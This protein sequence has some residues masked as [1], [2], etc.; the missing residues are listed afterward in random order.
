M[1]SSLD[2]VNAALSHFFGTTLDQN[3]RATL[4]SLA[5]GSAAGAL[6]VFAG[7]YKAWDG[8]AVSCIAGHSVTPRFG[9]FAN[10][11][12][13]AWNG[14]KPK[15]AS[16]D[17]GASAHKRPL[18]WLR[19][20]ADAKVDT[21][22]EIERVIQNIDYYTA[23]V[24]GGT[25]RDAKA[26]AAAI[27]KARAAN[28]IPDHL[29]KIQGVL[30]SF[31]TLTEDPTELREVLHHFFTYKDDGSYYARWAS[32]PHDKP[33]NLSPEAKAL[34]I[35]EL[36]LRA[37][38]VYLYAVVPESFLS[39]SAASNRFREVV[40]GFSFEDD[41]KVSR[42]SVLHTVACE[43]NGG[44]FYDFI[45]FHADDGLRTLFTDA[46]RKRVPDSAA[47][48]ITPGLVDL[49]ATAPDDA[50][51]RTAFMK[52]SAHIEGEGTHVPVF[53][54]LSAP[55]PVPEGVELF[56][57]PGELLQLAS[58]PVGKLA[59]LAALPHVA[60]VSEPTSLETRNTNAAAQINLSKEPWL[61]RSV[62]M[63]NSPLVKTVQAALKAKGYYAGDVDGQFG[64]DT[65]S[66][67]IKFQKDQSL[68]PDGVVG[69][70]T[71]G[72]LGLTWE[73]VDKSGGKGV[74]VGIIDSGIH[75][76]H[77]AFHVGGTA[78]GATRILSTWEPNGTGTPPGPR[79]AALSGGYFAVTYGETEGDKKLK[80][81][82]WLNRG[83]ELVGAATS[84][85]RDGSVGHGTHVA[86][87]AA[88]AAV[89]TRAQ[90]A[91]PRRPTSS[92][93]RATGI[94]PRTPRSRPASTTGRWFG[95]S[96][97]SARSPRT[98]P[99]SRTRTAAIS[100]RRW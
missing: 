44:D 20:Q 51:Q 54:E 29:D 21:Q 6:E 75:G 83:A 69:P 30:A 31:K 97:T 89:R 98:S 68:D 80:S 48:C 47:K 99:R 61:F 36:P 23:T 4:G 16:L 14:G 77:P 43:I 76:I 9:I 19:E 50:A 28:E 63:M 37:G 38:E 87:I 24:A 67:V 35:T 94:P 81:T 65:K 22:A 59:E 78:G 3:Q 5:Q 73:P 2:R 84:A 45:A 72:K 85:M 90:P 86:G 74:V 41:A 58:V 12:A 100:R 18:V 39:G 91:W 55:G 27:V 1:T 88:G 32:S 96:S 46:G 64:D 42:V 92:R 82:Q 7:T 79:L 13:L 34:D 8:G 70:T 26:W 40:W 60:W 62:P 33:D 93:S 52:A 66:A 17:P 15:A 11:S 56:G 95:R 25:A 10:P 71:A 49:L 57:R 53:L